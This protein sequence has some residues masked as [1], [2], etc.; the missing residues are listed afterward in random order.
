MFAEDMGGEPKDVA[1]RQSTSEDT[2][3][4]TTGADPVQPNTNPNPVPGAGGSVY[5]E[6]PKTNPV[7]SGYPAGSGYPAS[8]GGGYPGYPAP[9]SG[10][11]APAGGYPGYPA[12]NPGGYPAPNPQY[13]NPYA[14]ANYPPPPQGG[15]PPQSGYP[16]QSNYNPNYPPPPQGYPAQGGYNPYG[17]PTSTTKKPGF[18][19]KL[20]GEAKKLAKDFLKQTV[21]QEVN[22]SLNKAV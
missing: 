3:Q 15:Y 8:G 14:N 2:Q 10:Y 12:Q 13:P 16:S 20:A 6:L 7:P 4:K 11:P 17:E 22:K 5:P 9:N 21:L 1:R 19:D 18:F